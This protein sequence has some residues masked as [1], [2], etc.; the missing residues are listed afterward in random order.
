ML[1][2][3]FGMRVYSSRE[4]FMLDQAIYVIVGTIGGDEVSKRVIRV[5]TESNEILKF[6]SF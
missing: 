3:I 6:K 1:Y 4:W 5:V 2:E